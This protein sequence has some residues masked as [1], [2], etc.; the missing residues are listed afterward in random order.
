MEQNIIKI[1]GRGNIRV[2]PDVTRVDLTFKSRHDTYREAY[3]QGKGDADK[4]AE[5][6]RQ[7]SLEET[8]PKTRV[9]EV[10]KKMRTEH[11]AKGNYVRNVFDGYELN[12]RV[13][14]DLGMDNDML[15][16]LMSLV[17]EKIK[18][19]EADIGFTVKNPRPA[20]HELLEKAV[21]DAREKA[22]LMAKAC[23]CRLGKVRSINYC[24]A[25]VDIFVH[26]RHR[27][28]DDMLY[29]GALCKASLA[30][31]PDDI[32]ASDTVAIEW[33]IEQD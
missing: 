1:K 6:M 16:R 22:E 4:L 17:A 2:K 30:I 11:D 15:H 14:I 23:G 3:E 25:E 5:I 31:N 19:V 33:Y 29:E 32:E 13:R 24:V 28:W 12:H 10:E 27:K 18:N 9:F 7:M 26:S 21:T 8:L 20:V